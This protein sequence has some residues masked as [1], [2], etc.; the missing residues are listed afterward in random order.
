MLTALVV[1]MAGCETVN[2][3]HR[4]IKQQVKQIVNDVPKGIVHT[5]TKKQSLSDGHKGLYHDTD[6][7]LMWYVCAV[8][9]GWKLNRSS[10]EYGEYVCE[11]SYPISLNAKDTE[12]YIAQFINGQNFAGYSD[13]RLPT[14]FEFEQLR[15]NNCV[16]WEQ[17]QTGTVLTANGREPTYKTATRETLDNTGSKII[18]N[19]CRY[20]GYSKLIHE[21]KS[22]SSDV[23]I[24]DPFSHNMGRYS[25][26]ERFRASTGITGPNKNSYSAVAT[27]KI[28]EHRENILTLQ[29]LLEK[30]DD[31]EEDR[32]YIV[33]QATAPKSAQGANP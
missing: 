9:Q 25:Y 21:M 18:I 2:A 16:A 23:Y 32:F 27:N 22:S 17:E 10:G 15:V 11:S 3:I 4:D 14:V 8:S 31:S 24:K 1:A 12:I 33:R 30:L 20:A 7:G 28:F 26:Y 29:L 13:W 6:T 5:G 19:N